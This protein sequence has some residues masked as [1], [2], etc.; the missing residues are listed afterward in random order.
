MTARAVL[1]AQDVSKTEVTH[2]AQ[3]QMCHFFVRIFCNI[4]INVEKYN[5]P[6]RNISINYDTIVK[7]S[8][9]Y[10]DITENI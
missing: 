2:L 6:T 9:K 3:S 4:Q 5:I 7:L 8:E 1:P 10:V